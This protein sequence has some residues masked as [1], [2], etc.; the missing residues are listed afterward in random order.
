MSKNSEKY[1]KKFGISYEDYFRT[2]FNGITEMVKALTPLMDQIEAL[3]KIK[4]LYIKK[5]KNLV[6]RL[7]KNRKPIENFKEFKEIYKEQISTEFMQHSLDF[8]IT[9]DTPNKITFKFTKCLWAK[10]FLEIN[11][12][13]L[14]YAMCCYPDYTM[15]KAFHPKLKLLRNK[16]LMQ[17]NTCCESTY[18]WEE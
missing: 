11:E 16:T 5:S 12:P 8:T 10:T 9:E 1:K 3:E 15:A 13:G 6:K 7:L 4:E 17:G 14:G 2:R 18:I